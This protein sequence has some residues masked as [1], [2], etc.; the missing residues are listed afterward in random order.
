M[1][2]AD[3]LRRVRFW[4]A[5]FMAGCSVPAMSVPERQC[6]TIRLRWNN[7]QV[8]VIRHQAEARQSHVPGLNVFLQQVLGTRFDPRHD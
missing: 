5:I 8:N 4:L 7:D 1:A 6:E 3:H 2:Q